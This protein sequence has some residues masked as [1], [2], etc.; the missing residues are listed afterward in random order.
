V[1]NA[2]LCVRLCRDYV[3][4]KLNALT[5]GGRSFFPD[6]DI[7]PARDIQGVQGWLLQAVFSKRFEGGFG[8]LLAA[9]AVAVAFAIRFPLQGTLGN[10]ALFILFVPAILIAAILGGI[11]PGLLA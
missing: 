10:T 5:R 2:P 3:A 6:G 7:M 9:A 4:G 1:D 11:G 8:Y